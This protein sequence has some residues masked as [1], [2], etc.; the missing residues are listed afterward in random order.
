MP[1]IHDFTGTTFEDFWGRYSREEYFYGVS[2]E[3]PGKKKHS[4]DKVQTDNEPEKTTM[5]EDLERSN[6]PQKQ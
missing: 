2:D 4:R 6:K 1:I 3:S 5:Q